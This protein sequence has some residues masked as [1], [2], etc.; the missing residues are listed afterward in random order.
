VYSASEADGTLNIPLSITGRS[1]G[2]GDTI[3]NVALIDRTTSGQVALAAGTVTFP[4]NNQANQNAVINLTNS[5]ANTNNV[6]E[7]QLTAVDNGATLGSNLAEL[8]GID[9]TGGSVLAFAQPDIATDADGVIVFEAED[10]HRILTGTDSSWFETTGIAGFQGTGA[11][12]QNSGTTYF[13]AP[14]VGAAP[15][16][17]TNIDIHTDHAGVVHYIWARMRA[18]ATL[19]KDV[20]V[21]TDELD[22]LSPP[23]TALRVPLNGTSEWRWVKHT[24]TFTPVAGLTTIDFWK[25][26]ADCQID[27]VAITRSNTY[28][29][30]TTLPTEAGPTATTETTAGSAPDN[31]DNPTDPIGPAP[32]TG[33]IAPTT[34]Y[35]KNGAGPV[36]RSSDIWVE[37]A[38]YS[39]VTVSE[40][41]LVYNT[42]LSITGQVVITGNRVSLRPSVPLPENTV[43]TPSITAQGVDSNQALQNLGEGTWSF[44]SVNPSSELLHI[45]FE[46]RAIGLYSTND[47][48][49]DCQWNTALD[50][51]NNLPYSQ[52]NGGNGVVNPSTEIVVEPTGV[53][54]SFGKC[55][56]IWRPINKAGAGDTAGGLFIRADFARSQEVY[57]AIKFVRGDQVNGYIPVM[58]EK[59]PGIITSTILDASHAFNAPPGGSSG[60]VS[61]T[62]L[63][64]I[65]DARA[66]AG[67]GDNHVS[68]YFYDDKIV[69]RNNFYAN[70]DPTAGLESDQYHMPVDFLFKEIETH[71]KMNT[72][73][74]SVVEDGKS[75]AWV[76]GVLKLS[77]DKQ[78]RNNSNVECDGL[79]V[80]FYYGG[81]PTNPDNKAVQTQYI[82]VAEIL[83]S[84]S[85]ITH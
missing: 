40:F 85:P 52:G 8:V 44:T 15:G 36:L 21:G 77:V 33:A 66:R 17:E 76:D 69:Q 30:Y 57:Y 53:N 37:Y 32:A 46:N 67:R 20:W 60:T 1:A 7:L 9:G 39:Q 74:P 31:P 4:N 82:Y 25:N 35:P 63:M 72:V 48:K 3:A 23:S 55:L 18:I 54:P 68:S 14:F 34:Q 47:L 26:E 2:S 13:T 50:P 78:W 56:R 65:D 45:F 43:F 61:F 81:D 16:F 38:G 80:Y 27:R 84:L 79:W 6:C 83:V 11:M 28:T 42:T 22:N 49:A 71:T 59:F 64:Q 70:N 51:V 29:P 73:T 58:Q 62:N 10:F 75:E 19:N 24:A 5:G 41:K 12:N